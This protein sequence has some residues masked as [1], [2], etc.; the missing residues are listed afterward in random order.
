[1]PA[2]VTLGHRCDV[3]IGEHRGTNQSHRATTS[4]EVFEDGPGNDINCAAEEPNGAVIAGS[5]SHAGKVE[6]VSDV[7]LALTVICLER[8]IWESHQSSGS[9]RLSVSRY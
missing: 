7:I 1:M 4:D 8:K 3:R 5:G 6:I 2:V 9:N